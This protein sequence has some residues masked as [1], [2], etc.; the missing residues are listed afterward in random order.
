VIRGDVEVVRG[1]VRRLPAGAVS[2]PPEVIEP[3]PRFEP[4]AG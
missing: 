3:V 1:Q 2:K 4:A